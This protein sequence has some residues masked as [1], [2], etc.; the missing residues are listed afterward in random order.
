MTNPSMSGP[1]T[2]LTLNSM[3]KSMQ[4]LS[5]VTGT[6]WAFC[7]SPDSSGSFS[8]SAAQPIPSFWPPL[9][10]SLPGFQYLL[11]L[12]ILWFHPYL[13]LFHTCHQRN[14]NSSIAVQA[15]ERSIV[16]EHYDALSSVVSTHFEGKKV[17]R[18]NLTT[19]E[20]VS[21]V[22]SISAKTA[23]A[24]I[25]QPKIL[26]KAE[27]A[28]PL[29]IWG[30]RRIKAKRGDKPEH[31][32]T[33]SPLCPGSTCPQQ[34]SVQRS[35]VWFNVYPKAPSWPRRPWLDCH[36]CRLPPRTQWWCSTSVK[37]NNNK[38]EE[39][40]WMIYLACLSLSTKFGTQHLWPVRLRWPLKIAGP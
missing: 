13:S 26:S 5:V 32:P 36:P 19:Q 1:N 35:I 14:P 37:G 12:P 9:L 4:Y 7:K 24:P 28:P 3:Y 11:C 25:R 38:D 31:A 2:G 30:W 39:Q 34:P 20:G 40:W 18:L 21:G 17:T 27:G 8:L 23:S 29:W 33:L 10:L 22:A 15:N 6:L 16:C